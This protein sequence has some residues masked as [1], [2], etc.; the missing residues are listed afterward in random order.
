MSVAQTG[1][2]QVVITWESSLFPNRPP[3]EHH[4]VLDGEFHEDFYWYQGPT[5]GEQSAASLKGSV[6]AIK[7][8][9]A[10]DELRLTLLSD[11]D[12]CVDGGEFRAA[13]QRAQGR[14]SEDEAATRSM[15]GCSEK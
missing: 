1:C 13:R 11:G 7:M 14:S 2:A 5:P 8:K 10:K 12:L 15:K 6:L 3:V 9:R 4:L